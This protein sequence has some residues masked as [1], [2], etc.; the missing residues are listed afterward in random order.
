MDAD[1]S[2]NALINSQFQTGVELLGSENAAIRLGGITVLT[3]MMQLYPRE[4]HVRVMRV[5]VA[6]LT[7]PS[8]VPG[9]I[10]AVDYSSPDIAEII[11]IINETS[12]E[13]RDLEKADHF[14]LAK[15]LRRTGFSLVNGIVVPKKRDTLPP[16]F[17]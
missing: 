2:K 3:D 14:D 6:F 16:G 7:Q 17:R 1:T 12:E 10:P 8:V 9:T 5:F 13:E 11:A 4:Y 15:S